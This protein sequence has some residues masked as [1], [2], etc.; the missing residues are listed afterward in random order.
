M[1]FRIFV[2]SD[3]FPECTI[4]IFWYVDL[5]L[6]R[7]VHIF[8]YVELYMDRTVHILWYGDLHVPYSLYNVS[9]MGNIWTVR[10][11]SYLEYG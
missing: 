1:H 10:S 2:F 5:N 3:N 7:T 11:T 4:H 8:W 6:D 9:D